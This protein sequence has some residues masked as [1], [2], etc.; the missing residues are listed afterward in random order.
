METITMRSE[1]DLR[2]K[3]IENETFR[4]FVL[5]AVKT[6]GITPEEWNK[7]KAMIWF[8]YANEMIGNNR[9]FVL[10]ILNQ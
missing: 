5:E 1:L 2:Y 10:K 9:E 6:T 4:K 3:L 7:E 8:F